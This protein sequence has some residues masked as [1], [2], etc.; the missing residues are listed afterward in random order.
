MPHPEYTNWPDDIKNFYNK[1]RDG[2][3]KNGYVIQG[4]VDGKAELERPFAYTIG[5][6][7]D[8]GAEFLCFF[9]IKDK[10]LSIISAI[11]NRIFDSVKNG[12]L[13]LNSQIID[14]NNIYT[15]PLA[16]LVLEEE[17]K[18]DIESVWPKQLE[19]DGILA[20]FSTNDHK[21][22]LLICTDKNGY[23]PWQEECE[24]YWPQIC[25]PLLVAI[26]QQELTGDDSLLYSLEKKT[27]K[28]ILKQRKTWN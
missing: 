6:S 12:T 24:G 7:F 9:P 21:L 1:I 27:K 18:K 28:Q 20:E 15:L 2:I 4:T 23:F 13:S 25:P 10:G 5:A 3:K 8:I 16:M 17:I 26:A 19:R 14:D 11:L 22:I